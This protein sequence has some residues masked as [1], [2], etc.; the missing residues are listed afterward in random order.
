MMAYSYVIQS[1]DI[2]CSAKS[3]ILISSN[4]FDK[5]QHICYVI[6]ARYWH[7]NPLIVIHVADVLN[8]LCIALILTNN[9]APGVHSAAKTGNTSEY[10]LSTQEIS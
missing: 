4:Q 2:S 10:V 8:T 3:G 7:K 5:C 6:I 9:T 1:Y